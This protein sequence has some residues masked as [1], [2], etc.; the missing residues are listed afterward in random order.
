MIGYEVFFVTFVVAVSCY[1][2]EYDESK[3]KHEMFRVYKIDFRDQMKNSAESMVL[4]YVHV[5]IQ[6]N[7]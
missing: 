3:D 4:D 1:R 6:R 7:L 5:A 2:L